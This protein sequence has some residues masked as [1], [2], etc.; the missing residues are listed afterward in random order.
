MRLSQGGVSVW[1]GTPDAPAPSGVI[2][3]G[4]DTS[5]R[6]GLQPPD[7]AANIT[8]LYRINHGAPHIIA[9][10]PTH[11][12]SSG[13][14]YFRAQL[15]GFKDG[16]KVEY[17]AIYRS[18]R[19]QIPSN[20][21]A[22]SHVVTF[23]LGVAAGSSAANTHAQSDATS[24]AANGHHGPEAAATGS[25]ATT[26]HAA[27]EHHGPEAAATA[28]QATKHPATEHHGP[29]ADDLKEALRAV[30]RASAVLKSGALENSFI[31]LYFSHSGDAQS[32]WQELGKHSDLKP[33]VEQLQF[34]LQI[35]LLTSGH[36]P[37]IEAL[38]KKP[39]VKSMQDLARWDDSVW[40]GLI[41]K[42]GVPHQI[43][44][45]SPEAKARFYAA[46]ILATLQA[47]FPTL[48]VQRIA[49][50]SHHVDPLA[51]K[52]IENSPDF[53]IRTTRVDVYADHH[54]A[55]AFKGIA[56]AKR[57]DALKE[58]KRIQRLFAVS[59]N[60]EVF[61]ALLGTKFDSAHAIAVVPRATF[62]SHYAHIFGGAPQATELHERA[63]FINA[64]NLHLRISIQDAIK[65]PPTRGLGHHSHSEMLRTYSR[66]RPNGSHPSPE[67]KTPHH[68]NLKE[69]SLKED[70]VKRFPNS[71]ELFGSISL[72]NCEECESAIGPSAYLV[73]VFDFLASSKPNEHHVTPLDVLIGNHEKRIPGRRPDL[74]FLNLTCA[75]TNTAMPY[76]D[77][78]NEILESYVALGL[79][80]EG[81]AAHDTTAEST[82]AELDANPQYVNQRAYEILDQAFYPF[83]LPFNRPLLVARSYLNQLGASRY[84]ILDTFQKDQSSPEVKR[85]LAAEFLGISPE[86]FPILT[87][88]HV[89]PSEKVHPRPIADY[90]GYHG[91]SS[92]HGEAHSHQGHWISELTNAATF[93]QRTGL[94][95]SD[96]LALVS[97]RFISP[98]QPIGGAKELLQRI[99]VSY[100]S[101]SE[102]LKSNLAHPVEAMVAIELAGITAPDLAVLSG[103]NFE[104]IRKMVVVDDAGASCDPGSMKLIHFDGSAIS[105]H[106]L[107]RMHRFI[108]LYRKVGWSIVD[109]DRA[110]HALGATNITP[111]LLIHLAHIKHLQAAY[112]ITNVQILL[113]L[114]AP[115]ESR[116][117]DSLYRGLF[118]NK[119]THRQDADPAFEQAFPD[120]EVLTNTEET[121]DRH[122]PI[123]RG[124]FRVTAIDMDLILDDCGLD[125]A[126]AVLD[127]NNV[128][129]LYRRAALAK[130]LKLKVK[131]FLTLRSVSGCDPFASPERTRHFGELAATI[132]GSGLTA[133]QLNYVLRHIDAVARHGELEPQDPTILGVAS[134][135]RNG[136]TAIVRDNVSAPDPT[137]SVTAQK[138]AT[139]YESDV[140][141][142]LLG[143]V[144]GTVSYS[145]SLITHPAGFTFPAQFAKKL[146]FDPIAQLLT[147]NSPL[148]SADRSALF[149]LAADPAYHAAVDSIYQQPLDMIK[150]SM[151][152]FLDTADAQKKLVTD[153]A[154]LDSDLNPILLDS[155]GAV[156]ADPTKAQTTAIAVKF[157][158]ILNGLLPYLIVTQGAALIKSTIS[159]S[160][161]ITDLMAQI[162]VEKLLK[163]RLD[164]TKRAIHDL[165]SLQHPGLSAACYTSADLTG[166]AVG[167]I[168]HTVS[169]DGVKKLL[170]AGT[171]SVSWTGM[172]A[173]TGS[174]DFV[175]SI[176][177]NATPTLWV[178]DSST[179]L[180][181][182]QSPDTGEWIATHISLQAGHLYYLRLDV[183]QL[184]AQNG[185]VTLLWQ[186]KA[187][188]KSVVPKESLYPSS[189]LQAF[190]GTYILLHK[191]SL[192]VNSLKLTDHDVLFLE[193][194]HDG[195]HRLNL[196]G[197][198]VSRDVSTTA[199]IDKEAPTHFAGL[200]RAARLVAFR[201]GLPSGDIEVT[202]VFA[203][204]TLDDAVAILIKVTGW[205]PGLVRDLIGP[206]GFDL[207]PV[208]LT[209]ERWPIRLMDCIGL[210]GRLG[211][212]P[213]YLFRWSTVSS[214]FET[215]E[216]I[217]QEI[218]KC[219]HAQYDADTWLT[220]AKP[221]NDKLRDTQRN[222]LVA[223][224]LPRMEL[225]DA[226]QLFEYFLI[227]PE[228]SACT[229]TSRISVAHS[230]VQLFVQRCLMNLEESGDINEV[231]PDQ[232]D[233]DQWEKWRKHYRF[234]QANYEVLLDPENWMQQGFRDDKTP[235]FTALEGD[236]TQQEITADNVE[237]AY[238]NY[239]EKLQQVA[240]LEIIGTFWQDKDH[241]TGEQ[242]N[243]LHVFGRTF[244][245]PHTYFYRTLVNFTT[246][247]PW[248][249]T[250]VTI[251]GDHVM[252]LIWNRRL[253][254]FWPTFVKKARPSKP[255]D[256]IEPTSKSIPVQDSKSYWQVSL[257]WT[258]L[259]H[260]KWSSKQVS[261]NAFDMHTDYF[262]E[263]H[264]AR[265]AKFAYSFKT[266]IIKDSHGTPESLVI[267]C[268]FNGPT[269]T[270]N[271]LGWLWYLTSKETTEVVGAFEVAGCTG[272]SVEAIFG[273]MPWPNPITPPEADVEALTFVETPGKTG[274]SLVKASNL[275]PS[276]FLHGSP[277]AYRLLYPHQFSDYLL[278]AP[279]FYQDKHSTFFVYPHEEADPVHQV[280]SVDHAAFKREGAAR[281]ARTKAAAAHAA[282]GPKLAKVTGSPIHTPRHGEAGDVSD[283]L[284][285]ME[286]TLA[287]IGESYTRNASGRSS[288]WGSHALGHNTHPSNATHLRFETFYHPF[289]C[290]FMKSV[291]RLGIKGLLTEANQRLTGERHLF[292]HQYKPTGLV[293]HPLPAEAVDFDGG[294]Y[295]IYNQELFFHIPDL[296]SERLL[297]NQRFDDAIRWLEYIFDPTDDT[298]GEPPPDRYWRY[299]PLK[300]SPRDN[301]Q[302]LLG[303]M[304]SGDE[305][306]SQ[307][308]A[309]WA[310]NPFEPYVIAR[311][312]LEAYKKNIFMK[313]VRTHI[314]HGDSLFRTDS[315]EAINEAEQ[316]YV[317]AAHLLGPRPENIAARTKP[318]PECYVTLRDKLDAAGGMLVLLENEFP[319]SGKVTTH[320]KSDSG[321]M[322][323]MGRTLYFC[324]PK[325][326]K[327]LEL[328]DI[329]DDRLYKIRN[330]L[331][332][333]GVFR[334]LA[335]FDP[336]IDPGMLVR[337]AALGIDLG[338]VMGDIQAPL[339][340]YRF[341]YMLQKALEMCNECRSFGGAL[342][343]A[344]EKND[345]EALAVMRSTH[346]V[347][348]LDLMHRVK[349]RQ[350]DEANAQVDALNASR[351][352]AGQR[353]GYYQTLNGVSS[354]T[355]P[356]VGTNIPLLPVPSQPSEGAFGIQLIP[357]EAIELMLST[358]ASV[359][360]TVAAGA[361]AGV[362]PLSLIP[363]IG[364]HA[365]PWGIGGTMT[366]GGEQW[367]NAVKAA[368]DVASF[369]SSIASAAA[370]LSGKMGSYFRRQ[371]D[372]ALQN[373]LAA[374]EIMQIDRQIAAAGIRVEIAQRELDVHEKQMENAQTILEYMTNKKFTNKDLYG[375]MVSDLSSSYFA[376]YQ[377][378]FA[379]AKKAERTFRFERGLTESNFIQFGYWDSLRKGLLAGDRLHLALLQMDAAYTDQ[380]TREYEISRDLSLLLNAPLALIS[381]KETGVCEIVVPESFFDADYPGHYMRRIKSLS[382]TIPCVVGPYTSLNCR[383][384][385]LTN[386]TR[387]SSDPGNQYFE[388][389]QNGD[390]RFV[391]NFAAVQS[392]ATSHGLNDGGLFEVNFR[393][394]RYLPF[395]G[396][397]GISRW[398]LEMPKENNAFDF[399]SISDVIFQFKYTAREGG[400]PLRQAARQALASGP[401]QDLVRLFSVRHEFP[402]DWY[403]FLNPSDGSA[404]SQSMTCDLTAVRFPYQ[405]RGKTISINKVE[406][407]LNFKDIHDAQIY[408]QNGT[409]LGDY[410]AGKPLKISLTPP[411]GT[412]VAMQL[413]S[414][415]SLLNGLPHAS[416]DVSDQTVGLGTWT[417]DVQNEDLAGLP[418]SLRSE[419]G[420]S[421]IYRLKSDAVL[422]MAFVCHYS[423]N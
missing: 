418:P 170:P 160:L 155:H 73:D 18:G 13:K 235:F 16:D 372:W 237:T 229:E 307:L 325:N 64:R 350:L 302:K 98:Q 281:A 288:A 113:A 344:L 4:A 388:D 397:G 402:G 35:D 168:D 299:I 368:V 414:D 128:S 386:K 376:C 34:A 47:A 129:A 238:M 148:T 39:G 367:S 391:N 7:P 134:T 200:L 233:S 331:N 335:L 366:E 184:P 20:Q 106:V 216:V 66:H 327:L 208:D 295:A 195:L 37:L 218:K 122:L 10:Q 407:F 133:Q 144:N 318:K 279:L 167:S 215:L 275:Q 140:V 287:D 79:K 272:E 258:E 14:Q 68:L 377:M 27:T 296:I 282:A 137:G 313:Y 107:D 395:E 164:S 89:N 309:D 225:R 52:F 132:A 109:L 245:S 166:A 410:R 2:A 62:V 146:T 336:P 135:L 5:V 60:S 176:P 19:R 409:P 123:L 330:C 191:A 97:T 342:L 63:Q 207:Q 181:L 278:Q 345:A 23:T 291:S 102:L 125:P 9:A 117:L 240:R 48:T 348:I 276:E 420:A 399:E 82:T 85:I 422:D 74:A 206:D 314:A 334:Q 393:D 150:S 362:I 101:L 92:K 95:Y 99:P 65:T 45:S 178:E 130:A 8:V 328:W 197:L 78:V 268:V 374:C 126:T 21:E 204:S 255:P 177:T 147:C 118:L 22:E 413:K 205:D 261:K 332:F 239:L 30:L 46:S 253:Y 267:R 358:T 214:D 400:D 381:L 56:E 242:V 94:S 375:W 203:A 100:S 248:E 263:D 88:H 294:P 175:F 50:A 51:A 182:T 408:S 33:H 165:H 243:I 284:M 416:A 326:D 404:K 378:A 373:N 305:K 412:A 172:I 369:F 93:L 149:G 292:E 43:P 364:V 320:P 131:D 341:S 162:L 192:V 383:L 151:S 363:Q 187:V 249:E 71:D 340:A 75:N 104:K 415:K 257:A 269:I 283:V 38:V 57:T 343:A 389:V 120:S 111:E 141:D 67:H 212:S 189:I 171:A 324:A 41:A 3:A 179:P 417:I 354:A 273:T 254:V 29:Q 361:Q 382:L 138:L 293:E 42:S 406:L 251:D 297:Q 250:Q 280:T 185:A 300:T 270:V 256:S 158:Y 201:R 91:A 115:V 49:A 72:C 259:R 310:R 333:Q 15:A 112:H 81:S 285:S 152:A 12:D 311:H 53:D 379:H 401:Q 226:N 210:A 61:R 232:I 11:Q 163:S 308:I 234:W 90:Y 183:V 347:G 301:I 352:T 222:A 227:D 159:N 357:E 365:Q 236:L 202:D 110:I 266:S 260:N 193:Q 390:D 419:G 265:Y 121:L 145:A 219:V 28:S 339:P 153:T 114:W 32:F 25:Q 196:N 161:K 223:Y 356:A 173:P 124:A 337:A 194:K 69:G 127:I 244:H 220:I 289:V 84:D 303:L 306:H 246:W 157:A 247:T 384:T 385:L 423:V 323:N 54:A 277:T 286:K 252:P 180:T 403:R 264:P 26:S 321:G 392:I 44:G 6:I 316:H 55:T 213:K 355:V 31:K 83:T 317:I 224:L 186:S 96:L 169:F 188:R 290:D 241:D 119:A 329:V 231:R 24:H 271:K 322:Q 70:L 87:E 105:D 209:N 1:Y 262:V 380:N 36:L 371:A 411:G 77:I 139:L 136:M 211:V 156:T 40:H 59:T 319:F 143:I 349:V 274:L 116:G 398:R 174:G 221:L 217:G 86:E 80:P 394:E 17:V 315:K 359:I 154:S 353:Y 421:K 103:D 304:E 190:R 58:V 360:Q 387:I 396:A 298:K 370:S 142:G 230:S 346:E 312:R 405:F 199:L 76:I 198:P 351:N 108:R 228:M 338:S